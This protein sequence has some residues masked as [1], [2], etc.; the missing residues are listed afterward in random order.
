MYPDQA[1]HFVG[2]DLGSICLQRLSAN[3]TR[4]KG[5][6]W[7]LGNVFLQ[8]AFFCEQVAAHTHACWCNKEVSV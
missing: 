4:R 6:N 8:D 3:G 2:P 1:K 5:L 7:N